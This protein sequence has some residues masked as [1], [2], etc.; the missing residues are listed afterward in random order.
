ML[1]GECRLDGQT[2]R[3]RVASAH[4]AGLQLSRDR[5]ILINATLGFRGVDD[6][7]ST[8]YQLRA[9]DY[10]GAVLS[11]GFLART[12][13]DWDPLDLGVRWKKETGAPTGF[14]VPKGAIVGGR[15][16]PHANLFVV[17]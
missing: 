5:F 8:T 9:G 6:S 14:G 11:E 3:D 10:D 16:P 2:Y 1:L 12:S 13:M 17:K 15:V 7:L 4:P